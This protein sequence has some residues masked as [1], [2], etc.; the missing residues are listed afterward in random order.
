MET[1]F[2]QPNGSSNE[3]KLVFFQV[4]GTSSSTCSISPNADTLRTRQVA[5]IQ[6]ARWHVNGN[7]DETLILNSTSWRTVFSFSEQGQKH[8]I[9]CAC[10]CHR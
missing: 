3:G 5:S 4:C 9:P 8:S 10:K 7:I 2:A 1:V 6:N